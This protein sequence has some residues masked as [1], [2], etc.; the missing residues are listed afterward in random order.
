[1]V[2]PRRLVNFVCLAVLLALSATALWSQPSPMSPE[3]RLSSLE[4]KLGDDR[5]RAAG[6]C[7]LGILFGAFCALWA[8]NTGRSAWLWFFLGLFFSVIAVLVVLSKNS[9]DLARRRIQSVSDL[10]PDVNTRS[11]PPS[12]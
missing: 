2:K 8:Q 12:G 5:E 1:M 3:A 9:N 7:G 4:R 11:G 6:G 10:A